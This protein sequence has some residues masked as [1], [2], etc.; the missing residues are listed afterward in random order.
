MKK[1]VDRKMRQKKSWIYRDLLYKSKNYENSKIH[2]NI[3]QY[4]HILWYLHDKHI[5]RIEWVIDMKSKLLGGVSLNHNIVSKSRQ[6]RWRV[7]VTSKLS[8]R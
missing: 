1:K 6:S 5:F 2:V 4:T 7:G 3:Y 8:E